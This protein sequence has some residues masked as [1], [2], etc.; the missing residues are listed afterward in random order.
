MSSNKESEITV[1]ARAVS[2]HRYG[3]RSA[4]FMA[5]RGAFAGPDD[6]SAS[7]TVVKIFN[8]LNS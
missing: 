1:V 5:T 3:H 2:S 4:S 7:L 6:W 8:L